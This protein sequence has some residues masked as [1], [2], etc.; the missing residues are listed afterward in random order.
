MYSLHGLP[1]CVRVCVSCAN[2]AEPIEMPF[3]LGVWIHVGGEPG[4]PQRMDSF[5]SGI[6]RLSVKYREYAA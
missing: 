6:S 4:F 5:G 2:T 3:G 1:V